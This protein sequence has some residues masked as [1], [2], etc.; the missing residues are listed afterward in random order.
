MGGDAIIADANGKYTGT[1]SSEEAYGTSAN[2][3]FELMEGSDEIIFDISGAKTIGDNTVILSKGEKLTVRLNGDDNTTYTE[4]EKSGKDTIVNVFMNKSGFGKTKLGSITFQ[5]PYGTNHPDGV[6]IRGGN[7]YMQT[8]DLF[9][10]YIDKTKAK[11]GQTIKGSFYNETILGSKKADKIYTGAGDDRIDAYKGKDK[12]YINGG[13]RKEIAFGLDKGNDTL[14]FTGDGKE[15]KTILN[16][17]SP[18]YNGFRKI[19]KNLYIDNYSIDTYKR[20]ATQTISDYFDLNDG[21]SSSL[22]DYIY[23]NEFDSEHEK[24][25]SN[26]LD[27]TMID[28]YG[29]KKRNVIGTNCIVEDMN[30]GDYLHG[31]KKAD[32]IYTGTGYDIINAGKGND[33]IYLNS[34]GDKEIIINNGDGNDTIYLNNF[35]EDVYLKINGADDIRKGY[36]ADGKDLYLYHTFN[37]GKSIKTEKTTIKDFSTYWKYGENS[38]SLNLFINGQEYIP[39][40]F[41]SED[42]NLNVQMTRNYTIDSSVMQNKFF[43][44]KKADNVTIQGTG[45]VKMILTGG[46]NDT[47]T[48]KNSANTISG[49]QGN[50]TINV[51]TSG[52]IYINHT[53]GD[54]NDT[55]RTNQTMNNIT[56]NLK[57]QGNQFNNYDADEY[58]S[59]YFIAMRQGFSIKGDDLVMQIPAGLNKFETI[60]FKDYFVTGSLFDPEKINI[61]ITVNENQYNNYYTGTL[62]SCLEKWGFWAT[63]NYDIATKRTRYDYIDSYETSFYYNGKEKAAMYGSDI[64]DTYI[65]NLNKKSNLIISDKSGGDDYLFIRAKQSD[66]S[67]FFNVDKYKRV[68]VT[69]D[70]I[71]D[72]LFIFN[73]K[74]LTAKNLKNAFNDKGSGY[75]RINQFFKNSEGKWTQSAGYI[76]RIFVGKNINDLAA[77]NYQDCE[78]IYDNKVEIGATVGMIAEK[79]AG[80]LAKHSKYNDAV[81]V[82]NSGN[83]KD[84]NSLLKCYTSEKIRLNKNMI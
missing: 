47:I 53:T 68:D 56:I 72:D 81:S 51:L 34:T 10:K 19:G 7:G 3:I 41:R 48:V 26:R 79:V 15:A 73:K 52:D 44:T 45:S 54:G 18:S 31:S 83:T 35:T 16:F 20:S 40:N 74:N 8:L 6:I 49:G 59:N 24:L 9:G 58:Y 82:I 39:V 23:I 21:L 66:L 42:R 17:L 71:S 37:S 77:G 63:M 76:E 4:T 12:I 11:K 67:A 33:K 78:T 60:T 50:D 36:S 29:D 32:K 2:E 80:W 22:E 64:D 69:G 46:G 5:D 43:G 38:G 62:K 70:G 75:I 30:L 61:N 14:K 27:N 65:I 84:I 55:I 25:L 57:L 13:G 28:V 1:Y